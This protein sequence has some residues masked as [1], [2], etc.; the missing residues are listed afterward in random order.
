MLYAFL[1]F[2][3]LSFTL[4]ENARELCCCCYII[5]NAERVAANVYL[6]EEND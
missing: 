3:L 4:K 1:Y 2:L 6:E 5:E